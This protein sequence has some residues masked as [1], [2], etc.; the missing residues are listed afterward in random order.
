MLITMVEETCCVCG[1]TFG[2]IA[3]FR[4][5]LL[6]CQN[7]FYCPKGHSQH[8][9]G[10]SDAKKYKKYKRLFKQAEKNLRYESQEVNRL[11]K[12]NSALRGVITKMKTT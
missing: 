6:K 9:C 1:I 11:G 7:T 4:D 8:F 3:G 2:I 5:D 12:S 10:E